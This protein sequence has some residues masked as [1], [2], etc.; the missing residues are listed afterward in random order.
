[1][2]KKVSFK[3]LKILSDESSEIEPIRLSVKEID[4]KNTF[5]NKAELIARIMIEKIIINV[6]SQIKSKE[7]DSLLSAYC[8]NFMFKEIDS[9]LSNNYP[10][11]EKEDYFLSDGLLL[12]PAS[13]IL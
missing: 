10:C 6:F 11:Y 2:K 9:L 8:S 13:I 3:N 1:M 4:K 12:S 5:S 7:L